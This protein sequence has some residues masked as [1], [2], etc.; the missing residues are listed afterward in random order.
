MQS[1]ICFVVGMI[2]EILENANS[3]VA[4]LTTAGKENHSP[5]AVISGTMENGYEVVY[6]A[7]GNIP[8]ILLTAYGTR[9][10]WRKLAEQ[11][12]YGGNFSVFMKESYG[13]GKPFVGHFETAVNP[14]SRPPEVIK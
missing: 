7:A 8:F 4:R 11:K 9:E 14:I 10:D 12:G 6:R 5:A 3:A 1:E 13:D 2:I